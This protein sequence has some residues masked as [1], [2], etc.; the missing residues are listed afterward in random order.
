MNYTKQHIELCQLH[1]AKDITD[2]TQAVLQF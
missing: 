1:F 2:T